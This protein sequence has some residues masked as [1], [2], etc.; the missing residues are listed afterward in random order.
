VR[1]VAINSRVVFFKDKD[2]FS[3]M[4]IENPNQPIKF[5]IFKRT[6]QADEYHVD[7]RLLRTKNKNSVPLGAWANW[8]LQSKYR[9]LNTAAVCIQRAFKPLCSRTLSC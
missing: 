2:G 7:R 8:V 9:L 4:L 3:T 6:R 1:E 5:P